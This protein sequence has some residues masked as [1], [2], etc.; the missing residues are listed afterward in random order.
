[1]SFTNLPIEIVNKII[2]YFHDDMFELK[3]LM[4]INN[5]IIS[6]YVCN[7]LQCKYSEVINL[8][9][10]DIS[11]FYKIDGREF[12]NMAISH[13]YYLSGGYVLNILHIYFNDSS[14]VY[15]CHDIDLFHLKNDDHD[16]IKIN[17]FVMYMKNIGF[18][19]SD[20]V[21]HN[22]YNHHFEISEYTHPNVINPYIGNPFAKER[23]ILRPIQIIV[24]DP[25]YCNSPIALVNTFDISICANYISDHIYCGDIRGIMTN[26]FT[27]YYD[28][29]SNFCRIIKY[30]SRGYKPN[31][32][33]QVDINNHVHGIKRY[34]IIDYLKNYNLW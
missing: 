11:K 28:K 10:D 34:Q 29:M 17:E 9:A 33:K 31:N 30:H 16:D 27:I 21:E 32:I 8:I 7:I 4:Q 2:S 6:K 25:E 24:C 19:K 20:T 15:K 3:K 18:V 23:N 12:L 14:C 5:T 1:M 13:G 22:G 26:T